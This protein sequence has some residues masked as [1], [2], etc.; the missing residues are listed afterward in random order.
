MQK[1]FAIFGMQS[2]ILVKYTGE[3]LWQRFTNISQ[4]FNSPWK[5]K[6]FDFSSKLDVLTAFGKCF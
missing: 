2:K 5:T 3:K 1:L 6:S 4:T